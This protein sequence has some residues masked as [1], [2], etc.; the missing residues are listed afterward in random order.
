MS[1]TRADEGSV[2]VP[3]I[4]VIGME[5][6]LTG[7]RE[8]WTTTDD[9]AS[10]EDWSIVALT[11]FLFLFVIQHSFLLGGFF[12]EDNGQTRTPLSQGSV[13]RSSRMSID[14]IRTTRTSTTLVSYGVLQLHLQDFCKLIREHRSLQSAEILTT[15]IYSTFSGAVRHRFLLIELRRLGKK[16]LWLRLDRRRDRSIPVLLF[17]ATSSVT[18]HAMVR[19]VAYRRLASVYLTNAPC[20]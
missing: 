17:A 13:R 6:S 16:D 1:P 15:E 3:C 11:G 18:P 8:G 2:S 12:A 10:D 19:H 14:S 7:A 9:D 4:S 5:S 20:R